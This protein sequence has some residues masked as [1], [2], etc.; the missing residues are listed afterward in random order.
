MF[1]SLMT[2][3]QACAL[4]LRQQRTGQLREAETL[5]RAT[6]RQQGDHPQIRMALAMV[7]QQAGRVDE[8]VEELH[9]ALRLQPNN[10]E[11]CVNLGILLAG[12][13]KLESAIDYLNRAI[14]LRPD[15]AEAHY[16][17]AN[18]FKL[19]GDSSQAVMAYQKALAIRPDFAPAWNNLGNLLAGQ[20]QFQQA[21]AALREAIRLRPDHAEAHNNLGLTLKAQSRFDEA[22]AEF[23][24]A[25]ELRPNY[26]EAWNNLALLLHRRGDYQ[27]AL[28][29]AQKAIAI[30]LKSD[31]AEA[32]ANL[33]N[34]LKDQGDLDG[35]I[36]AC[37]RAIALRP[38][39]P[40]MKWNL[41]LSLLLK[42][43]YERGWRAYESRWKT[44]DYAERTFRFDQPRWD[45]TPLNGQ[46]I[47]V[48]FEQGFGDMIQ[49]VRFIPRIAGQGG[50]VVALGPPALRRML[51]RQCGIGQY[52][53]F[54]EALPPFDC[55]TL[56]L[57]LPGLFH[58]SLAETSNQNPYLK[59]D[60]ELVEQWRN[61]LGPAEQSLRIGLV[62]AGNPNYRN[63][64]NRSVPLRAISKHLAI[65][66]VRYF[67]LQK[68]ANPADIATD[69]QNLQMLDLTAQIGDFADTAALISNLDLV[70]ACDT[71][72]AHLAGAIGKPVWI[73]LPYAPDWRWMLHRSDSSWYPTAKLFRQA[74]PGDWNA[75]LKEVASQLSELARQRNINSQG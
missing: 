17:L 49:F 68:D 5:L 56:L 74:T 28:M 42:G 54:D 20:N 35:A 60:P 75:P 6:S 29:A 46:T 21:D 26:A 24:R 41:A 53:C 65:P 12:Q 7:L 64:Q 57:S 47:L 18:A 37:E 51:D 15:M 23:G 52:V 55:Y 73:L 8:A 9:G 45:G 36:A 69:A 4:A 38:D 22:T 14:S 39:D 16:N 10:A 11:P 25:V 66:G 43:D 40:H 61:R 67:S 59:I 13:G 32:Y 70:I 30:G 2:I 19:S 50:K 3:Q 63:D 31:S 62:W 1:E 72:V 71:S 58:I 33:G 44:S 34:V 48:R 27:A